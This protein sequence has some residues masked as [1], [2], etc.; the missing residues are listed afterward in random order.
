M[1]RLQ[2][3]LSDESLSYDQIDAVLAGD[4]TDIYSVYGKAHALADTGFVKDMELRQAFRRVVNLAKEPQ[5][6][7][8]Q[9]ELFESDEEKKLYAA[10]ESAAPKIEA[11]YANQDYA[12]VYQE[13]QPLVAPINEFFDHV[14]VMAD[15]EEVRQNRLLILQNIAALLTT[16][17]DIKKLVE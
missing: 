10:Y 12:S 7:K 11:A 15:N 6:G 2:T 3:I 13:L 4:D 1:Q 14:I 5:Q 8:V 16:W 17:F 9:S